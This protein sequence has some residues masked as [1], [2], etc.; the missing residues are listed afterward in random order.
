MIERVAEILQL[1]TCLY[2]TGV[3]CFVQGVH[4]PLFRQVGK[5]SFFR[6]QKQHQKLT[7][8]IVVGPMLAE[9]V[10]ACI[11]PVHWTAVSLLALIWISTFYLQVPLHSQLLKEKSEENITR[12]VRSNYLRTLAW[13]ARSLILSLA[14]FLPL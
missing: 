10:S 11:A 9:L 12:L 7:S 4:Y 13:L 8:Y 14:I 1:V 6:Y 2:M 3:I 5:N